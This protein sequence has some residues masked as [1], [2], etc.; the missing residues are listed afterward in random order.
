[1]RVYLISSMAVRVHTINEIT[2]TISSGDGFLEKVDDITYNG[3]VP[4]SPAGHTT[5]VRGL[6][7]RMRRTTVCQ[8]NALF[9]LATGT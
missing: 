6:N 5:S 3:D 2:P 7:M 9:V 1:M 4:M 8:T